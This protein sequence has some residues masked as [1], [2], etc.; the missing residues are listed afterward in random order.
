LLTVGREKEREER[1]FKSKLKRLSFSFSFT[2]H[3]HFYAFSTFLP[4]PAISYQN[5]DLRHPALCT[6][7]ARS[8]GCR[9]RP[10]LFNERS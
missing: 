5:Y 7:L 8:Q 3:L 1:Q 9:T 2:R 4:N 10:S 6:S